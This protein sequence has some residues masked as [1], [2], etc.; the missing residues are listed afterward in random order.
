MHLININVKESGRISLEALPFRLVALDVGHAR[1][2][3]SVK[4]PM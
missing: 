1:D 3:V 4:A 2:A